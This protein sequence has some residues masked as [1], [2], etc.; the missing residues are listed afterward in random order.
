MLSLLILLAASLIVSS[1]SMV[2]SGVVMTS[3]AFRVSGFRFLASTLITRSLSV[4]IPMGFPSLLVTTMQPRPCLSMSFATLFV[5][6]SSFMV[7]TGLLMTSLTS[8]GDRNPMSDM[9]SPCDDV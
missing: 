1:G 6:A 7:I 2:I 5:V 3:F 8:I 4:I 9:T